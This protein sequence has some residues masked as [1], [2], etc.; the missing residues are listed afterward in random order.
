VNRV[1]L[2]CAL[3]M[4]T[5]FLSLS[6][7]I[8]FVRLIGFAF[9]TTPEAFA[10]VLTC[11]L[12]GIAIG[13]AI[14]KRLCSAG[15]DLIA[16]SGGVLI[17]AAV[18]DSI[19]PQVAATLLASIY[20]P[21]Q[22]AILIV[23]AAAL[24]SVLFPIAHQLGAS[25]EFARLGRSISRVYA[26][27]IAGSTLGPLVTGF[28]LLD[29]V[30]LEQ[31]FMLIAA[32]TLALA[33]VAIAHHRPAMAG[34]T[35]VA[36]AL[37]LAIAFAR[38]PS[39]MADIV[40]RDLQHGQTLASLVEGRSGVVHTVEDGAGGLMVFGG[41]VNDGRI[42]TS[43]AVNSNGIDRAYVLQLLHPSPKR[44]LVIGMSTGA[45]TQVL[46]TFPDLSHADV[47]EI[48]PAYLELMRDQPEVRPLLDDPRVAIHIDDGRRWLMRHGDARY[49][50]IVMNTS[51]HWRA[52]ATNLLSR[53]FLAMARDRLEPGGIFVFN[54]TNSP[55][56][57]HTAV[58]VFPFVRTF[59]G[60]A[61]CATHD[62][63]AG[64]GH[65]ASRLYELRHRGKAVLDARVERD[66]LAVEAL[67]RARFANPADTARHAGRPIDIITDDNMVTEFRHGRRGQ[68]MPQLF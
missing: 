36:G 57:V 9:Y 37:L 56:A 51:F 49:D 33:V 40:S 59:H 16:A 6:Q 27:N 17:V 44:A 28:W 38:P 32:G 66:R 19:V 39:M 52:Y 34:F 4:A 1:T 45:W 11:F 21:L 15:V 63:T 24:K 65:N 29:V 35:G 41:N 14:G 10:F 23:T 30:G 13:A 67:A 42:N 20:A 62:F 50:L 18:V 68:L 58:A 12:A 60:T 26:S 43:L 22:M 5:G 25:D 3:S 55:D 64:F 61:Y 46:T 2:A 7:E 48:N 31:A 8:L 53:E 54:T 47:V